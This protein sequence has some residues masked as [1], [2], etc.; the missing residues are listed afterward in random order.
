MIGKKNLIGKVCMHYFLSY[1]NN[2]HLTKMEALIV[3][4]HRIIMLI[5]LCN[6]EALCRDNKGACFP[7]HFCKGCSMFPV[8]SEDYSASLL[9]HPN[10]G[11]NFKNQSSVRKIYK[12]DVYV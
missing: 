7:Q 3:S 5:A 2:G 9:V 10:S 4:Q 8:G 6:I 12:I 1:S 11:N